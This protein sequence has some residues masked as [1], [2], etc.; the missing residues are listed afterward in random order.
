L[1]PDDIAS[2]SGLASSYM[3]IGQC[4]EAATTWLEALK[5][6]P[7][8]P[9]LWSKL[10]GALLYGGTPDASLGAFKQALDLDVKNS[11]RW[12]EFGSA[13]AAAGK[14][15]EALKALDRALEIEPDNADHHGVQADLLWNMGHSRDAIAAYTQALKLEPDNYIYLLNIARVATE[16]GDY[17]T[18]VKAYRRVVEIEPEDA[19][20]WNNLGVAL[21]DSGDESNA[22]A[23]YR[24]SL[25][26][27][28]EQSI[29][30]ENFATS[31]RDGGDYMS[32]ADAFRRIN[33]QKWEQATHEFDSTVH[34]E[35]VDP[36]AKPVVFSGTV[37]LKLTPQ[38]EI[39]ICEFNNLWASGFTGYAKVTGL[40]MRQA[41]VRPFYR[42]LEDGWKKEK[43]PWGKISKPLAHPDLPYF[44][45]A[46]SVRGEGAVFANSDPGFEAVCMYKDYTETTIPADARQYFPQT[47]VLPVTAGAAAAAQAQAALGSERL[48]LKPSD[49]FQGKGVEIIEAVDL[50]KRLDEIAAAYKGDDNTPDDSYWNKNLHPN[51]VIQKYEPSVPVPAADGKMYNGT[52]RVAFTAVLDPKGERQPQIEFH[53]AYWKLPSKDISAGDNAESI[54][55]DCHSKLS[56]AANAAF[57]DRPTSA[58]VSLEHQQMVSPQLQD[59]LIKMLPTV[60]MTPET[61]FEKTRVMLDS[62]QEWTRALGMR[63]ATHNV[64][65]NLMVLMQDR[66]QEGEAEK[67]FSEKIRRCAVGDAGFILAERLQAAANDNEIHSVRQLNAAISLAN[68]MSPQV[69]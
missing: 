38:G 2:L 34:E 29:V 31:C 23:A 52:M 58:A 54:I 64:F 25:E 15:Y 66:V 59:C 7:Q 12:T 45:N 22:E 3:G 55:S 46:A 24:K 21:H 43:L 62:D 51:I 44:A 19:V 30:W 50:P 8:N 6:D 33:A 36:A 9:D 42:S 63:L 68:F 69:R 37:D 60:S 1:K 27:D 26:L 28:D 47:V 56:A 4:K 13:C 32:A 18:A 35:A 17:S 39:K 41:H 5:L 14:S 11:A 65:G 20:A 53:G 49:A 57:A 10:G 40:D 48:V 61:L 16:A 67:I